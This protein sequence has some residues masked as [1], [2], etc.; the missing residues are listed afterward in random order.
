[1]NLKNGVCKISMINSILIQ[2]W[3]AKVLKSLEQI[4]RTFNKVEKIS[5]GS[6]DSI[7]S[8]STS[9]KIQIVGR[10]TIAGFHI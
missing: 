3:L 8:P 1:M 6:L 5:K 7:P 10:N 2:K 9:V 4:I